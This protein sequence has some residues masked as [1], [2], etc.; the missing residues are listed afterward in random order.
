VRIN[1]ISKDIDS[2]R[3]RIITKCPECKDF[4]IRNSSKEELDKLDLEGQDLYSSSKQMIE[5]THV[6]Y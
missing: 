2:N 3:Y 1:S 4:E 6:D 5:R